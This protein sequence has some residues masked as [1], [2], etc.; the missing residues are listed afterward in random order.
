MINHRPDR[1][2]AGEVCPKALKLIRYHVVRQPLT[3]VCIPVRGFEDGHPPE[4]PANFAKISQVVD[5]GFELWFVC[6]CWST[7]S[8][9][10][11]SG[12]K[13]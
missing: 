12:K 4:T 10:I 1:Y 7:V 5:A 13:G 11:R 3:S 9:V 6:C 2:L 8:A